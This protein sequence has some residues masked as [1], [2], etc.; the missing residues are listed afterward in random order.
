MDDLVLAAEQGLVFV[1]RKDF[2]H[3]FGRRGYTRFQN[4][5]PG[6]DLVL[7]D[8]PADRYVGFH[9]VVLKL[10]GE[11]GDRR[12]R[13]GVDKDFTGLCID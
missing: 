13:E 10:R 9:Q 11:P 8:D 6:L 4:L 3:L 5:P 1:N 2:A 7:P 12:L